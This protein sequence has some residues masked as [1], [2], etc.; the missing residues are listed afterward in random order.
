METDGDVFTHDHL[1][2]LRRVR[3]RVSR[4]PGVRGV[5][6][7]VSANAF[8]WDAADEWIEVKP[9]IE[10]IPSDRP[11]SPPCARAL[12]YPCTCAPWCHP[13]AAPPRS[14]VSFREMSDGDFIAA[15]LD[16]RIREDPARRD[17]PGPRLPRVGAPASRP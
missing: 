7:L 4:L 13:T 6:N 14:G 5:Q 1:S 17:A 15:D 10:E 3:D 11:R 16:G 12:A 9:F 8:R 2:A